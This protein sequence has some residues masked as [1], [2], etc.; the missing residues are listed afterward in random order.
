[1]CTGTISRPIPSFFSKLTICTKVQ[2]NI[3]TNY[4][5]T[6]VETRTQ[7]PTMIHVPQNGRVRV[8]TCTWTIHIARSGISVVTYICVSY[9]HLLCVVP[10]KQ[11]INFPLKGRWC[12]GVQRCVW[13]LAS[14]SHT[15]LV[16][17]NWRLS[18]RTLAFQFVCET[19]YGHLSFKV[20]KWRT[21]NHIHVNKTLKRR[22]LYSFLSHQYLFNIKHWSKFET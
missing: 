18:P 6:S 8:R 11:Q 10:V 20:I 14:W 19:A 2:Y 22:G 21:E 1:M 15:T 9:G 4:T 17:D 16:T 3:W 13:K 7:R 12:F 5:V